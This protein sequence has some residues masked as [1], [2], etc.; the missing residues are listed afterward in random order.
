[1]ADGVG[2]GVADGLHA[3]VLVDLT[4][5]ARATRLQVIRLAVDWAA[6]EAGFGQ[7]ARENVVMAVDEACQNVIRHGYAGDSDALLRVRAEL[8]G[9]ALVVRVVDA[10]PPVDP[11]QIRSRPPGEPG[12][13]GHGVRLMREL[14]DEVVY[15]RT[16][17]Q[18]GNVLRLTKRLEGGTR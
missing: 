13:G 15:E 9:D 17:R 14:L 11:S 10:A 1:L 5:P 16:G 12:P 2:D 7:T 18:I 8:G 4:V 6:G 3:G